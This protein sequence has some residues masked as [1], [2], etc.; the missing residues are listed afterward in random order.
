LSGSDQEILKKQLVVSV[1]T[2]SNLS[3]A[4]AMLTARVVENS[5]VP[6]SF[7]PLTLK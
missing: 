6:H 1:V 4:K 5:P 3:G 7:T 2:T